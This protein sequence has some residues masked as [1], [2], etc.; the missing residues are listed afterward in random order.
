MPTIK[1][2]LHDLAASLPETA[3]WQDVLYEIYVRNEVQRGMEDAEHGRF[4]EPDVIR[5]IFAKHGVLDESPVDP[6]G[7]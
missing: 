6:K 7:S 2:Q 1:E 5:G 3:T 4:A